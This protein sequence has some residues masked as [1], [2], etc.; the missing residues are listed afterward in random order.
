[1]KK[2][3]MFQN[4]NKTATLSI[5]TPSC[6]LT[7]IAQPGK[8]CQNQRETGSSL[9]VQWLRLCT[10]NAGGMGSIPGTRKISHMPCNTVKK[11]KKKSEG[12]SQ[13][14]W[15]KCLANCGFELVYTI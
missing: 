2:T 14:F 6:K 5:R 1:M 11:K 7:G 15:L 12:N 13:E 9:V 4:E 10:P 8:K 3:E